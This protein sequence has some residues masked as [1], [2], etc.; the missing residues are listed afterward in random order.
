MAIEM[1][2]KKLRN[3]LRSGIFLGAGGVFLAAQTVFAAP[4]ISGVSGTLQHGQSV[5]ISGSGFGAKIQGA[6]QFWD[7]VDNQN[8]YA[9]IADGGAVPAGGGNPWGG[10]SGNKVKI[11][12]INQRHNNSLMSY[13]AANQYDARLSDRII[14][15]SSQ[16]YVSWWFKPSAAVTMEN[17]ASNKLL[18]V[19]NSNDE[20]NKTYSW[21]YPGGW[22]DYI[23]G[24][25]YCQNGGALAWFDN[26]PPNM[27]NTWHRLEVWFDSSTQK[28]NS[29]VDGVANHLS[30]VSW[31][32]CPSFQMD[33]VWGIGWES[34][35]SANVLTYWMDDIYVDNSRART[36]LCL[37]GSWNSRGKCEIQPATAWASSAVTFQT[38]QG[39]FADGSS[40]YLYVV[41]ANGS[42]NTNGFS[43]TLGSSQSSPPSS[44]GISNFLQLLADWLTSASTS[45]KNSDGLVN[46]KDLGIM[47]SGWE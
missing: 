47:M 27:A 26:D 11:T 29:Y 10:N 3:L 35:V 39:S 23:Y 16:F 38:N 4:S 45:D 5:T 28:F 14:N 25:S 24:G 9:G 40:A 22:A 21:A 17:G 2:K 18:R 7:T 31:N 37:G 12:R 8:S 34:N 13:T 33:K 30:D 1:P 42:V 44:Y 36:E 6:P 32:L 15:A 41:D 43:V 19:S 20:V 46:T